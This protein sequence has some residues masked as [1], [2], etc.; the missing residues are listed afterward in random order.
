VVEECRGLQRHPGPRGGARLTHIL[1]LRAGLNRGEG[2]T[3]L[4]EGTAEALPPFVAYEALDCQHKVL[5]AD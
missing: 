2:Q 4:R 1:R 5:Q 3:H